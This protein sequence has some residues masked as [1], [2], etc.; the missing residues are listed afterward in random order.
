MNVKLCVLG[1]PLVLFACS[2]SGSSDESD[3]AAAGD[4]GATCLLG[5]ISA[6][7]G[8]LPCTDAGTS[9]KSVGDPCVAASDC[10]AKC[11]TCPGTG[12]T[13]AA[14]F[15]MFATNSS[16]EKI[17]A[18]ADSACEQAICKGVACK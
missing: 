18:S 9:S 4:D 2:S 17:C 15:C 5:S 11:C 13:Y 12:R 3:G 14:S 10:P 6:S 1:L 7:A 8:S 16:S